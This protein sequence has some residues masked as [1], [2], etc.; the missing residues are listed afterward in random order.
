MIPPTLFNSGGAIKRIGS[1]IVANPLDRFLY[2]IDLGPRLL[3]LLLIR[4][5]VLPQFFHSM[6][7]VLDTVRD[8]MA[9]V[10]Y[11]SLISLACSLQPASVHASREPS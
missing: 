3:P 7:T 2:L 1:K 10:V 5:P 11:V 8:D 6:F 9:C 4:L